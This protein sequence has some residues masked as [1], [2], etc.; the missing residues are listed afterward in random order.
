MAAGLVPFSFINRPS[1]ATPRITSFFEQLRTNEAANRP[2]GTAGYCWGGK[3]AIG[4]AHGARATNERPLVD[5]AFAAHPSGLV[6]SD[7]ID[8]I[9]IPFSMA[10]GDAD[11]VLGMK[12]VHK[13][14]GIL[15]GKRGVISE[16]RVYPGAHH[17]FAVRGNPG[18]EKDVQAGMK[19]EDQAVQ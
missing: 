19:A 10:V 17:G 18:D 12:D 8:R 15:K 3:H 1:V 4:L 11:I 6:I 7:D 2:L 5:C 14:E 16:V 9:K 13:V